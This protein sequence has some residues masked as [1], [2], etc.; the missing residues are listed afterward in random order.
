MADTKGAFLAMQD[1]NSELEA[2]RARLGRMIRA[3]ADHIGSEE[4]ADLAQYWEHM[5]W[6][7]VSVEDGRKVVRLTATGVALADSLLN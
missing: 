4:L 6:A 3:T 5:G 7:R 2:E 1:P